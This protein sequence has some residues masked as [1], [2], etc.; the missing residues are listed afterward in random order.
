[1]IDCTLS[2]AISRKCFTVCIAG[3]VLTLLAV[4]CVPP[5]QSSTDT[6]STDGSKKSARQKTS[7]TRALTV[8]ATAYT[9]RPEETNENP[10]LSACGVQLKETDKV[11]AVSRDLESSGLTCGT[12]ITISTFDD[13]IFTVQDRT[14]AR[15]KNKIDIFMGSNLQ[16]ALEWGKRKVTIQIVDDQERS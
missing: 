10:W 13:Q 3:T 16:K 1:M 11:I 7:G 8:T 14:A 5:F 12:R 4:G 2:I 9:A 6:V 15:W